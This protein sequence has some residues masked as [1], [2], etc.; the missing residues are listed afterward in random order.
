MVQI[1]MSEAELRLIAEML[2]SKK[3]QLLVETRHTDSRVFRE[4]LRQRLTIVESLIERT[5]AAISN[6]Q[7]LAAT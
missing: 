4:E 3:A 6:K 2:E 1:S 5:G 7:A